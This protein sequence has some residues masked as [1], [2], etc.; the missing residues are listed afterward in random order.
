MK[1]RCRSYGPLKYQINVD[2]SAT[3]M[4]I[5]LQTLSTNQVLALISRADTW[6]KENTTQIQ[7]ADGSGPTVM[8]AHIGKRNII[9]MLGGTTMALIGISMI[10]V[11]PGK[12][13]GRSPS[14]TGATRR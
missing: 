7:S 10:L 14:I 13:W 1:N 4:T 12:R 3:R 11:L 2:K 9:S 6:I 8:F 5:S